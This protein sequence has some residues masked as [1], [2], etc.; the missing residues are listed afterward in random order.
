MIRIHEGKE[1]SM[2][3]ITEPSPS[4]ITPSAAPVNPV[5]S[6]EKRVIKQTREASERITFLANAMYYFLRSVLIVSSKDHYRL[7]VLH[8]DQKLSIK[9][10]TTLRGAKVG[11]GKLYSMFAY[12]KGIKPQWTHFYSPDKEWLDSVMN[13]TLLTSH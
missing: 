4:F 2:K 12:K 10:Y 9:K 6:R 3:S 13:H 1:A 11:F 7:V 5:V 8:G